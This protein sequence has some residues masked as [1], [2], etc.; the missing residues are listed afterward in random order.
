MHFNLVWFRYTKTVHVYANPLDLPHTICCLEY[1]TYRIKSAPNKACS[2]RRYL[3]YHHMLHVW[4][5]WFSMIFCHALCRLH[6]RQPV[7]PSVLL[8]I[9][10]VVDINNP[11]AEIHTDLRWAFKY[12]A[13][14]Y[15]IHDYAKYCYFIMLS[16]TVISSCIEQFPKCATK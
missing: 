8:S 11:W 12:Y 7:C 16:A 1:N 13:I 15:Y 4:L 14:S 5:Q 3:S 10:Y 9:I 2:I 6:L